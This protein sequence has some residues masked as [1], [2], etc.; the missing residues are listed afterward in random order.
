MRSDE[1]LMEAFAAGD[2]RAVGELYARYRGPLR[3]KAMRTR[4]PSDADDVVQQTF[5]RLYQARHTYRAGQPVRPWLHTIAN[6][7][8]R[9]ADR[10][11]ARRRETSA[12]VVDLL[13]EHDASFSR[14]ERAE[15]VA[16]LR[17]ALAALP[18]PARTVVEAHWLEET[19]LSELAER[20]GVAPV[21][22]RVRAHRAMNALRAKM[23][24]DAA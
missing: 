5:L 19:R 20:E 4:S 10:S 14:M 6:N 15:D 13:P 16:L 7:V 23:L 3:A 24:S 12:V 1:E 21:N 17:R 22:L 18:A 2:E 9:D 8:R 11:R